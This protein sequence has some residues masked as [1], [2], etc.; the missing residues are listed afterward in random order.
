MASQNDR[1]AQSRGFKNYAQMQAW[2]AQ[3]QRMRGGA[4]TGQ[5]QSRNTLSG[6]WDA[7]MA[8]HPSWTLDYVQRRIA[9]ATQK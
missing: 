4:A 5:V 1:L 3:Q 9:Q 2:V 7:A 6:M 8:W